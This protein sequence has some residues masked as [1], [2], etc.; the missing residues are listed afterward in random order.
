MNRWGGREKGGRRASQTSWPHGWA[1]AQFLLSRELS[2]VI[3]IEVN[4]WGYGD[5]LELGCS[6]GLNCLENAIHSSL[7][8]ANQLG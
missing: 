5:A 7:K 2:V 1:S 8:M 3:T 6:H 4:I